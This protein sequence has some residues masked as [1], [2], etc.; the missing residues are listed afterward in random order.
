MGTV[1][2]K[3]LGTLWFVGHD[4]NWP[5]EGDGGV[6]PYGHPDAH[7]T[8]CQTFLG[9]TWC[10]DFYDEENHPGFDWRDSNWW[11]GR[12]PEQGAFKISP[13]G[14][15]NALGVWKTGY[16]AQAA[17]DRSGNIIVVGTPRAYEDNYHSVYKFSPGGGVIASREWGCFTHDYAGSMGEHFDV[18]SAAAGLG[19]CTDENDNIYVTGNPVNNLVANAP[20]PAGGRSGLVDM[21]RYGPGLGPVWEQKILDYSFAPDDRHYIYKQRVG[22]INPVYAKGNLYIQYP[23][24]A[25]RNPPTSTSDFNPAELGQTIYSINPASG[26]IRGSYTTP[27]DSLT[28]FFIPSEVSTRARRHC[29]DQH[30]GNLIMRDPSDGDYKVFNGSMELL[31]TIPRGSE[32]IATAESLAVGPNGNLYV[33]AGMRMHE[34]DMETGELLHT[35]NLASGGRFIDTGYA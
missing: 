6:W 18:M 7:S 3:G 10:S 19:V 35:R 2:W 1:G 9:V 33:V 30:T 15:I 20:W 24:T 11:A 13:D 8:L 22:L 12:W 29:A 4:R 14:G 31:K 16:P 32:Q 23:G 21:R 27:R 34:Y 5:T 28:Y 17:I 26:A 25:A